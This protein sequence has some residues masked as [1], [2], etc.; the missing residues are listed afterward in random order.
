MLPDNSLLLKCPFCGKEKEVL[1]LMSG[2]TIHGRQWSDLKSVY[3]MLPKVSPIQKC[4]SCGKYYFAE[5]VEKRQGTDYS[6]EKGE[7]TYQELKE[8]KIQFGDSLAKKNKNTLNML[9]LWAYND[10]YNREGVD[11]KEAPFEERDY[12]DDVHDELLARD[13][14]DNVVYAEFLREA[15]DFDDALDLLERCHPQEEYLAKIVEKIKQ[16]AEE[17]KTIAFEIK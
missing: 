3:P 1:S 17:K 12:I 11:I 5:N 8:A 15:G 14:V 16:Y 9:L 6:F 13:D 2:N 7:L 10:L 4:P